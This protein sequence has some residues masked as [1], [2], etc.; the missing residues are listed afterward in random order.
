MNSS[1]IFQCVCDVSS[2][3]FSD[4][5]SEKLDL[6][7]NRFELEYY[8]YQNEGILCDYYLNLQ[9]KSMINNGIIKIGFWIST[10][11]DD[12]CIYTETLVFS[13]DQESLCVKN[14]SLPDKF[15]NVRFKIFIF[16]KQALNSQKIYYGLINQGATCYLNSVIHVLYRIS[17]FKESVLKYDG[18]NPVVIQL[19][20]IFIE[21]DK[22]DH[23]V[24]TKG[25][26]N[27]LE[28][29]EED[30]CISNDAHEFIHLLYKNITFEL[31]YF[32]GVKNNIITFS[33]D[34]AK[35]Q[36]SPQ[37]YIELQLNAV[38]SN[39]IHS[40]FKIYLESKD[41]KG[42]D[43]LTL[44]TEF[45][46]F[47]EYMFIYINRFKYDPDTEEVNKVYSYFSYPEELDLSMYIKVSNIDQSLEYSLHSVIV[48]STMG[49]NGHYH[50]LININSEWV[51]FD[52]TEVSLVDKKEVFDENFGYKDLAMSN[53]RTFKM[54][55][56]AYLLI[57]KNKSQ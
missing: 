51:K 28:W 27:A 35:N 25:L 2:S 33:N 17:R 53:S 30:V 32:T 6:F 4:F 19:K 9:D 26:T 40:A 47:P 3:K 29:D 18:Q 20:N 37:K 52:D 24:S 16:P 5:A 43:S 13:K 48:H 42:N 12:N 23:H 55:K 21:L 45:V 46:S 10:D 14:I 54:K 15:D 56:Y 39:D 57:Y 38:G 8:F 34:D 1:N 22:N 50:S 49:N 44:S 31:P 7:D 36:I 41:I 11:E